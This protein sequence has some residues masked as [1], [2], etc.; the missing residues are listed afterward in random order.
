MRR[1]NYYCIL[2]RNFL[3]SKVRVLPSYFRIS[4]T[5]TATVSVMPTMGLLPLLSQKVYA[6]SDRNHAEQYRRYQISLPDS[7]VIVQEGVKIA[8]FRKTLI[9]IEQIHNMYTDTSRANCDTEHN[10]CGSENHQRN[11]GNF[12]MFHPYPSLKKGRKTRSFPSL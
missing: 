7:I 12:A 3:D 10:Q 9:P 2:S 11:S 1:I 4:S 5:A 8:V 6:N